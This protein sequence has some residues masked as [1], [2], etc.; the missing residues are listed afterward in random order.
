[1][2][3]PT[4]EEFIKACIESENIAEPLE[5]QKAMLEMLDKGTGILRIDRH[6]RLRHIPIK[7]TKIPIPS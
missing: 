3:I 5:Y 1:M 7:D 4:L 2:Q 6:G